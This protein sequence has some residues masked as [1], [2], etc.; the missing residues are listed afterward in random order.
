MGH[1]WERSYYVEESRKR[2]KEPVKFTAIA[3]QRQALR[4][5]AYYGMDVSER[6]LRLELRSLFFNPHE[7]ERAAPKPETLDEDA[8]EKEETW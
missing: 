8:Q 6:V 4:D 7:A 3:E 1:E 2:L 5:A